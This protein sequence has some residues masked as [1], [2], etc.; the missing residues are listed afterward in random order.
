MEIFDQKKN[1]ENIIS[2][3]K[4]LSAQQKYV[5]NYVNG[6]EKSKHNGKYDYTMQVCNKTVFSLC[7]N[8]YPNLCKGN[9]FI[10]YFH[11]RDNLG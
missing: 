9:M 11:L 6:S 4:F 7:F 1:N 2:F 3:R 10:L 5:S 8:F